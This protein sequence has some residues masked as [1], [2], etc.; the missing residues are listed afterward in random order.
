MVKRILL[1]MAV[2]MTGTVAILGSAQAE[3]TPLHWNNVG[4]SGADVAVVGET[5]F[6]Y[7]SNTF[8]YSEDD[9]Q[10][11]DSNIRRTT[12]F[13]SVESVDDFGQQYT[14]GAYVSKEF[15]EHLP[16][17]FEHRSKFNLYS[18]NDEK[19]FE[20]YRFEVSQNLSRYHDI[21]KFR[22]VN[23][24]EFYVRNLLDEDTGTYK[25]AEFEKQSFSVSYWKQ[26]SRSIRLRFLYTL[27]DKDYVSDFDE[28]DNLTHSFNLALILPELL[29]SI[30]VV[31]YYE[32]STSDA[33]ASDADPAPDDDIS[34]DQNA[35]G[36]RL[37]Y[38]FMPQWRLKPYYEFAHKEYN[39]SQSVAIDPLHAGREDD[40]FSVGTAVEFNL[41]KQ[42]VLYIKY[43]YSECNPTTQIP[44]AL[45]TRDDVLGYKNH[46]TSFGAEFNF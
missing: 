28:R 38:D 18:D 20:E 17:T 35:F 16:T 1:A 21:L 29:S 27:D 37:T 12:K 30:K 15:I 14:V 32:Y 2:W 3:D 23:V 4:N 36:I 25:K 41:T 5:E 13:A 10:A 34:Y 7:E 43:D 8:R 40:T 6:V 39:T 31:P 9:I 45:T 19:N 33:E 42:I 44:A 26:I 22:Y 24:P 11:Y 46:T